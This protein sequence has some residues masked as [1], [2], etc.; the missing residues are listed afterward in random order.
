MRTNYKQFAFEI[1]ETRSEFKV[2]VVPLV[3]SAFGGKIK[4]T[5]KQI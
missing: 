2:K 3:I 4:G 5:L 1:S